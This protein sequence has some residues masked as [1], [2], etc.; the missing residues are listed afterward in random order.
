MNRR[1]I[2]KLITQLKKTKPVEDSGQPIKMG[3]NMSDFI[4]DCGTPACIAGWATSMSEEVRNFTATGPRDFSWSAA[5]WMDLDHDW[6][7]SHLFYPNAW[8]HWEAIEPKHAVKALENILAAGECYTELC[9]PKL[10]GMTQRGIHR[11][12]ER[13]RNRLEK[14]NQKRRADK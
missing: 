2:K 13:W 1:N 10:W 6:C 5:K 8:E 9:G 7:T 14:E 3:F 11:A 4:Y 12:E